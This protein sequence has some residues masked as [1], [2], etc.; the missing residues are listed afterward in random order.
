MVFGQGA[1]RVG[2]GDDVA[3][4]VGAGAGRCSAMW[5]FQSEK[6]DGMRAATY[7]CGG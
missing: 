7:I 4:G 2:G 3:D 6:T 5:A 1:G